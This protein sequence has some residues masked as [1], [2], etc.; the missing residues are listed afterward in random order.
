MKRSKD[1]V[2]LFCNACSFYSILSGWFVFNLYPGATNLAFFPFQ[3][4]IG[5]E[6]WL[7]CDSAVACLH[8]TRSTAEIFSKLIMIGRV[9]RNGS[10]SRW[11]GTG[12]DI[13]TGS[14]IFH[15]RSVME[16]FEDE[17]ESSIVLLRLYSTYVVLFCIGLWL[18]WWCWCGERWY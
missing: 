8:S 11:C 7:G 3:I 10:L 9:A 13:I 16:C 6:W 18:A 5:A 12:V 14:F 1:D 17:R 2:C 15:S 4:Q